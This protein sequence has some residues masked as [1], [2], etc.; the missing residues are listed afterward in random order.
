VLGLVLMTP[1]LA[2]D[3]S[4]TEDRARL[5]GAAALIDAP[6]SIEDKVVVGIELE[7]AIDRA[8]A[9]EVP[10]LRPAIAAG[11]DPES[12]GRVALGDRLEAVISDAITR[13]FRGAFILCAILAALALLPVAALR[14]RALR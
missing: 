1:L 11:G 4:G 10:D 2:S 6:L 9:G 8:P 13:G 3:L 5:A 7:R 14:G 12:A